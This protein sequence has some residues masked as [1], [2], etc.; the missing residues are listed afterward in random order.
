MRVQILQQMYLGY[1]ILQKLS[2]TDR[3]V[4][5]PLLEFFFLL[6]QDA[7]KFHVPAPKDDFF[8]LSSVN[9]YFFL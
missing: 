1:E 7:L 3:S 8:F 4:D 6:K 5:L 2:L 9:I